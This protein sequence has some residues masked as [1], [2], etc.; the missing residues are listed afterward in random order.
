MVQVARL[1]QQPDQRDPHR[2]WRAQRRRPRWPVP[3]HLRQ[4]RDLQRQRS[5]Q[6]PRRSVQRWPRTWR[7]VSPP[8]RDRLPRALQRHDPSSIVPRRRSDRR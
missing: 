3:Q 2:L 1:H 5:A 4:W 8:R 7:R 6:R